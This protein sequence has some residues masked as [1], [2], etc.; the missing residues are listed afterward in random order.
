[1]TES[2]KLKELNGSDPQVRLEQF[3]LVYDYIKFH[4]GL[5]LATPPVFAIVAESFRGKTVSPVHPAHDGIISGL[6]FLN[7]HRPLRGLRF[8]C[9]TS[10]KTYR[11]PVIRPLSRYSGRGQTSCSPDPV[12]IA[13]QPLAL[14]RWNW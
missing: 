3:K 14:R 9:G 12:A 6:G 13:R 1:M 2:P 8:Q 4:I 10:A 5:Y 7:W 11:G